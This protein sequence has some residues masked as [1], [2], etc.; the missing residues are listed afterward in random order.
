MKSFI[1]NLLLLPWF[2]SSFPPLVADKATESDKIPVHEDTVDGDDGTNADDEVNAVVAIIK[3][4]T[5]DAIL[6]E[7]RGQ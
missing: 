3:G 5:K 7:N 2:A 4:S 1:L 6:H